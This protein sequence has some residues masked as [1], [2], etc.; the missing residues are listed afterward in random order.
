MY[1]KIE[2]GVSAESD[3]EL[4]YSKVSSPDKSEGIYYSRMFKK[5]C[6]GKDSSQ[7]KVQE[8][9]MRPKMAT[10]APELSREDGSYGNIVCMS[11]DCISTDAGTVM[12]QMLESAM[13]VVDLEADSDDSRREA[14]G[15]DTR[16]RSV[17]IYVAGE[18]NYITVLE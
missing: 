14:P 8:G 6:L 15:T 12:M 2:S 3:P 11:D 4:Y 9:T 5:E 16:G 13:P 7:L 10:S 1:L 17:T 18:E